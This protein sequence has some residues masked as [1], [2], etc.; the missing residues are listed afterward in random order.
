MPGLAMVLAEYDSGVRH[1]VLVDELDRE[2]QCAVTHRYAS[3]GT[4][5]EEAPGRVLDLLRD[6]DRLTPSASVVIAARQHQLR[7]LHRFHSRHRV[8]PGP[9]VTHS[10]SPS[11]HHPDGSRFLI[12][13]NRRIPYP[14][15]TGRESVDVRERHSDTH[16]F[17]GLPLVRASAH[18]DVNAF[19]KVN[20]AVPTNVIGPDQASRVGCHQARNTVSH[21][22]VV[23]RVAHAVAHPADNVP[24]ITGHRDFLPVNHNLRHPRAQLCQQRRIGI[25]PDADPIIIDATDHRLAGMKNHL[26]S[27]LRGLLL[28]H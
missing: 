15:L 18:T 21:R 3:S 14:V 17:P 9:A 5:Q 12:N 16:R 19:L 2:H 23:T 6:I 10:V 27:D 4:L 24:R 26:A 20:A 13:Q 8:S 25:H 11:G 22:M 28:H 1:P 7:G